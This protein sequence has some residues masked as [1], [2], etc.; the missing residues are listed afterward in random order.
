MK[1]LH[2]KLRNSNIPAIVDA[3]DYIKASMHHWYLIDGVSITGK[4]PGKL[5]WKP[6][7]LSLARFITNSKMAVV[8]HKDGNVFNN[9]KENLRPCSVSQ[10]NINR[11]KQ[12]AGSTKY[13]G[14]SW[15]KSKSAW[16]ARIMKHRREIHLG[17]FDNECDAAL[18]YNKAA[19]EHFGKFAVLNSIE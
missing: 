18:A 10:N 15:M 14:V 5:S 19:L 12:V 4:L 1:T 8:D 9:T 3:E 13:K 16:R 6:I 11:G 2:L 7:S 17:L